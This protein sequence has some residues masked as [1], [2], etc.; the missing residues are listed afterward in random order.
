MKLTWYGHSCFLAETKEG[1]VVFDPYAPGSV[2]GLRL[3]SLTADAVSC[4]HDH[5][6]H[7]FAAGVRL[8][9]GTPRFSLR[10]IPCFHDDQGGALRGGNRIAVLEAE[11]L[12][13]VHLGDLGHPLSAEQLAAVGRPDILLIPVGGYYTVDALT[14]AAV[15]RSLRPALT[16]PMHYRGPGFG[17][18]V[19]GPV[20]AFT[21]Q[22]DR[23]QICET[24]ALDPA[25][26]EAPVVVLRCP[27]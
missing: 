14:A 1:S 4:S 16:I 17:Y 23:V 18:E 26:A 20:D 24:N 2:P 19:I 9:G 25:R 6:D 8:T 15:V 11:G 10:T 27:V 22:F 12:C 21:A 7:S 13:L 3:P 5:R